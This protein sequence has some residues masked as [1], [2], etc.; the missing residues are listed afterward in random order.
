[1]T[2]SHFGVVFEWFF[3]GKQVIDC[4]AMTN[5]LLDFPLENYFGYI[6]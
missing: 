2:S 5:S 6:G 1:M 4:F 3:P